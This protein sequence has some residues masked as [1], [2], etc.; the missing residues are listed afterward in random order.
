M[1]LF[2]CVDASSWLRGWG[3]GE[4]EVEGVGQER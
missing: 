2:V 3:L 1:S 4:G